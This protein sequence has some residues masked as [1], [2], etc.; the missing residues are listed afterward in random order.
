MQS[1]SKILD[2]LGQ[3]I[4]LKKK[5]FSNDLLSTGGGIPYASFCFIS[6][7]LVVEC[8]QWSSVVPYTSL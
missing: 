3:D 1:K 5:K 6:M 4:P 2:L 8:S 7:H